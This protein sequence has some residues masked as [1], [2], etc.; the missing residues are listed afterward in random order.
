MTSPSFRDLG[1]VN[2]DFGKGVRI[3]RPVDLYGCEIADGVAI[4][5]FVE[6]QRI[7][8]I[9]ALTRIQSH[10]F[11]CEMVDMGAD[12]F[13]G[14][15]VMLVNDTFSSGVP[16]GGDQSMWRRTKLGNRVSICSNVTLLPV[17]ICVVR[18]WAQAQW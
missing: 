2:V 17:N 15:G 8:R 11:I 7:A 6:I 4:G 9:G 10:A 13:I 18:S 14:H 12:C 3:V 5:Q 1:I 16:A